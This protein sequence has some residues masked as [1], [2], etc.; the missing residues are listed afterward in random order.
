MYLLA[1][2]I[3]ALS[4]SITAA[5]ATVASLREA[6]DIT[7]AA[8]TIASVGMAT[9]AATVTAFVSVIDLYQ[10]ASAID[11]KTRMLPVVISLLMCAN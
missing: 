10:K 2:A 11:D 5:A 1:H 3:T 4:T 7:A 8:S 6:V 9:T